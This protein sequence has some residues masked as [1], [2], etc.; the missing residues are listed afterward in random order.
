MSLTDNEGKTRSLS[1]LL[2]V[3]RDRFADLTEAEKAEYAAGIAGK[4]AMSGLLAI[5]NAGESDY[6]R[7]RDAIAAS[8]GAAKEMSEIRL[9]NFQGQMTLLS[10]AADGLKLAIGEQLTPVLTRL[11]EAGTDA[12]TWATEFVSEN[13]WVVSAIVGLTGALGALVVG[14][15]ALAAAPAI[16]GA[17][18][19]ALGLLSANPVA[20]VVSAIVG[21]TAAVATW[22]ASMDDTDESV[23]KFTESLQESKQAYEDLM[24][25]MEK[26]QGSTKATA[27]A[28]KDLLA[29]EDKSAVQKAE[30]LALIEQ[31]NEAVP[32]L[33][34]AYDE[35]KDALVGLTEAEVESAIE[36][37]AAQEKYQADMERLAELRTEGAQIAQNLKDAETELAEA[38]AA[39]GHEF[40]SYAEAAQYYGSAIGYVGWNV[41]D[42]QSNV[43]SLT[44]SLDANKAEI[45]ALEEETAAYSEQ[46]GEAAGKVSTMTT[47][48]DKLTADME[49]LCASYD[50]S[51]NAAYASIDGQLGLFNKMDGEAKTSIDEL[52]AT[53]EGQASYMDTYAANIQRAMEMGVDEGLVKKLSDG[54][55]ESAQY[56]DAIVKGG[57]EKVAE[58]NE[59]FAKV[60]E[61]KKTFSDTV[62]Q[63]ET[64]F[65]KKMGEMVDDLEETIKE[66]DLYDQTKKVA[67]DNLRGLID[68]SSDPAL[69]KQLRDQYTL[70]GQENIAAYKAAVDQHSPSKKFAKAG[71]N[72]IQGL[73][74]GAESKRASLSAAYESLARTAME[75]YAAGVQN[76]LEAVAE[77]MDQ[78]DAALKDL[79]SFYG[80]RSDVG[81]LEYQLWERT[82]GKNASEAEKYARQLELLNQQQADQEEKVKAAAAVYETA[83]ELYGEGAQ[84]SY[85]YQKALLQEQL[86]LQDVKDEINEVNAARQQMYREQYAQQAELNWQMSGVGRASAVALAQGYITPQEVAE[87]A[88]IGIV[89][90]EGYERAV[91][92]VMYSK[93]RHLPSTLEE[94]RAVDS[95]GRQMEA[96]TAGVIN[97]VSDMARNG[98]AR[99]EIIRLVTVEGKVLAEASFDDLVDYGDANGTPI[100][101][102]RR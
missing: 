56:L 53:L 47:R 73:I 38:Q 58:L 9:D 61:G 85:E 93:A 23:K 88:N 95:L 22:A 76:N 82:D 46:H 70:M 40:S 90:P 52:I 51:Y 89:S 54:S 13:E 10:S 80:L 15:G 17:L 91:Q 11:V 84:G 64:D 59:Q 63:M 1:E 25:A 55:Q 5:V 65:D 19:T 97:A 3:L 69:R 79:D 35:E 48:V 50:E 21:L 57:E 81:N 68:G 96:M 71:A 94:P 34:L 43:Q 98:G 45:A 49:S 86:A 78:F 36:R 44:D 7:L 27:D 28:L 14:V 30:I 6:L 101:N 42:L 18:N 66:M 2:D 39:S 102:N 16:I 74:E 87:I 31:L 8:S 100:L 32:G 62:A 99:K 83:V 33:N 29:V 67:L 60:E 77:A 72:D 20:L 37:A 4:E 41:G 92:D 26:R 12:F 75:S 24:D